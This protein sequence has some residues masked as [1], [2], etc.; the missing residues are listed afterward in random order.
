MASTKQSNPFEDLRV[1]YQRASEL[2]IE[3]ARPLEAL[4]NGGYLN[5]MEDRTRAD[6]LA[7]VLNKDIKAYSQE[8]RALRA[9]HADFP[10]HPP[11][12]V[13]KQNPKHV[14]PMTDQVF[15]AWKIGNQYTELIGRMSATLTPLSVDISSLIEEVDAKETEGRY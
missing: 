13:R 2:L 4:V 5:R 15:D 14:N 9:K 6:E 10:A 7:A 8:L 12:H 1:L 3:S 11:V